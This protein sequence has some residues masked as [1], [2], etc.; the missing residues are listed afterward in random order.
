[1]EGMPP[2]GPLR[3]KWNRMEWVWGCPLHSP[4]KPQ[5]GIKNSELKNKKSLLEQM[6]NQEASLNLNW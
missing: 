6:E 4:W 3:P 2:L 1:M 5:T